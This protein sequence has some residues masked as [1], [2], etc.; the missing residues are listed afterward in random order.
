[1]KTQSLSCS[2][3]VTYA[4]SPDTS[5]IQYTMFLLHQSLTFFELI[6]FSASINNT[7]E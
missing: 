4:K 5:Q 3:R 2:I 7:P 1:M 6:T